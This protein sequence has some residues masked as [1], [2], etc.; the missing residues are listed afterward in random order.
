MK[1][2]PVGRLALLFLWL[3]LPALGGP[4]SAG[5]ASNTKML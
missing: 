3:F 5:S 2:E 4:T 1:G